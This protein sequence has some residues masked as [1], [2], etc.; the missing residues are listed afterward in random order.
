[1]PRLFT[2]LE[3]PAKIAM[4]LSLVQNGLPGARW[5]E[6]GNLHITLRFM[7]D[8]ERPLAMEITRS[9][10]DVK[11]PP[12]SMRLENLDV[13]GNTKPHLLF[14]GVARNEALSLLKDEQERICQ[15]LGLASDPRKFTPHVTLAR[16]R[17]V[18]PADIGK[19]LSGCGGYVSE[20]FEITRFVVFSSRD[21][22]GG[23]PYVREE[24]YD[25]VERD[26]AIA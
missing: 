14:A 17:G 3:I 24:V 7:G 15:R 22:T 26:N 13:F 25:L 9:L 11:T 21:S 5:V 20:S 10:E 18:T 16:I 1:M 12:F 4:Q 2:A 23:G 8:V 19:Y 6:R